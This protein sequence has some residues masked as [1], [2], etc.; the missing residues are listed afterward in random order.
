MFEAVK[1]KILIEYVEEA[2]EVF[3]CPGGFS[4]QGNYLHMEDFP[5]SIAMSI[6]N[7]KYYVSIEGD[8]G[9]ADTS[10]HESAW[11]AVVKVCELLSKKLVLERLAEK[12]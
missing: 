1:M 5:V 9:Y 11:E 6:A 10:K 7:G 3:D 8:D 2:L 12:E 4:I